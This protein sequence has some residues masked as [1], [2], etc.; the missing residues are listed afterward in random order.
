MSDD[1]GTLRLYDPA[2]EYLFDFGTV[3]N[4]SEQFQKSCSV[5][6]IVTKPK[7]SAFPLETRT[8]KQIDVSFTRKQPSVID[9]SGTYSPKWS[10]AEWTR[11]IMQS[12]DRWQAR[13]DGY[14]LSYIP[15]SD[16]PYIAP[17]RGENGSSY[18]TG[19]IKSLSVKAVKG[20]PESIQGSFSFHVGTMY[21][22]T[23]SQSTS[24]GYP[25]ENFSV[26]LDNYVLLSMAKDGEDES[27]GINIID[28]LTVTGGP[29]A[30]FE[31]A[32]LTIPRKALTAMYPAFSEDSG[33]V[34]AGI[35]KLYISMAGTSS[36]TVTKVKM[37]RNTLTITAY[38]NAECI[39]GYTISNSASR[40]PES[41]VNHI[42]TSGRYGIAFSDVVSSYSAPTPGTASGV[43]ED[44]SI[45]FPEGTNAWYALQTAAMICGARVFFAQ[46]K[47][48][49][50]DYRSPK[51][52]TLPLYTI[53]LYGG[54]TYAG[55]VVGDVDLNDEGMDTVANV[56]KVRCVAPTLDATTG[57]YKVDEDGN[58][59]FSTYEHLC[60]NESSIAIYGG[61]RDGGTVNQSSLKQNVEGWEES[62]PEEEKEGEDGSTTEGDATGE[63]TEGGD[64]GTGDE[65]ENE[66]LP[67]EYYDQAERFGDNYLS[68]VSE[69]QQTVQFTMR[70]LAGTG[71][72]SWCPF[73]GPASLASRIDDDPDD[74]FIDNVSEAGGDKFEKLALK[75]FTRNYPECTTEYTWGVLASMDLASNTSRIMSAQGN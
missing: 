16:N 57:Q 39:K 4:I 26:V 50:V 74:I 36:M 65:E 30:P 5:T 33:G 62:L 59:A 19:Y 70:E 56:I 40:T 44:L 20:R 41:W 21:I 61:E 9:D 1:R 2:N 15:S 72:G 27:K 52:S 13:T 32:Q 69:A 34:K 66:K 14:Q 63:G 47:A 48:Y 11:R 51:G 42:L 8:Y 35:S 55:S 58:V 23:S 46:D 54:T 10:N 24:G 37:S 25:R 6:P 67:K 18:E 31:Y 64:E 28:S 29:E 68:Y 73:F 3:T 22:K 60:R 53:D 12:L 38:C 43:A 75:T 17:I 71:S 49:V 45:S 7:Q